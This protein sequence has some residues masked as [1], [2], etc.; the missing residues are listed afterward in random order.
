MSCWIQSTPLAAVPLPP[1]I[2]VNFNVSW[3]L[4]V[5][6]HWG[7]CR[8][9]PWHTAWI[10]S[11]QRH[12]RTH[13]SVRDCISE[14]RCLGVWGKSWHPSLGIVCTTTCTIVSNQSHD[15]DNQYLTVDLWGHPSNAGAGFFLA[16]DMLGKA[17][18]IHPALCLWHLMDH[19]HN[20]YVWEDEHAAIPWSFSRMHDSNPVGDG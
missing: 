15:T 7:S 18:D 4:Q 11:L 8:Y 19:D 17:Q 20:Q 12:T 2:L 1:C 3:L 9:T 14:Q 5:L 13:G 16:V 10:L 6:G